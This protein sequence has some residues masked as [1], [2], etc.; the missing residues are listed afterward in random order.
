MTYEDARDENPMVSRAQAI[1][2]IRR[3]SLDPA[4]FFREVGDRAE[5]RA[6]EVLDWLGY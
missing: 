5:Y 2:E 3:H 6:M 1:A 4:D